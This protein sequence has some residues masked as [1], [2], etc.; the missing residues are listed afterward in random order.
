MFR[1]INY[2]FSEKSQIMNLHDVWN[3][4][5]GSKV[6][7]GL[8]VLV[9][10]G[11][12][13]GLAKW[14]KRLWMPPPALRRTHAYSSDQ[15]ADPGVSYPLKYYLEAINDSRKCVAVRVSEYQPNAVTLQKFVPDTLQIM[16]DGWWPRPKTTDSVALLPNQ[17]CRVWIGVDATKFSKADLDKL[18]GK[19]G[20][21]VLT[22][23]GKKIPFEL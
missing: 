17:R 19:I 2:A 22:A 18:E 11:L 7:A 3:D 6:I 14:P 13:S 20:T 15:R 23:N 9:V 16:L 12:L 8:M 10:S 21:L 4:P 1:I 5:V